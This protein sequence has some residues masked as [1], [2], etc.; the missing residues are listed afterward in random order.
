MTELC[1]GITSLH[2][3]HVF[4]FCL[5]GKKSAVNES[6]GTKCGMMV[7]LEVAAGQS[8]QVEVRL[9]TSAEKTTKV[10]TKDVVA[11][12]KQEADE[13]YKYFSVRTLLIFI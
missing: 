6:T 10:P 12:R 9:N 7:V 8:R 1:D 5:T 3:I 4:L 13:F 2:G 11:L